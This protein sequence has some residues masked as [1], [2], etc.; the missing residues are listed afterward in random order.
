[1]P[2][3]EQAKFSDAEVCSGER[4]YS[5]GSQERRQE[6]K[7]HIQLSEAQGLGA[8]MC[9]LVAQS[10][11]HLLCLL[12]WQVDSSTTAPMH[13]FKVKVLVTRS[14]PTLCDPMDCSQPGSSVH[15]ISQARVLE[16]VAILPDPG[17]KPGSSS[18]QADSL[19]SESPGKPG[20][21][22]GY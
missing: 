7:F 11:P 9:M 22:M 19:P 16:W 18:L 20:A 3:L 17:V 14:C 5:Q 21:F 12:H 4:V 15:G 10:C 8:F 2:N 1:M 6:N 13:V